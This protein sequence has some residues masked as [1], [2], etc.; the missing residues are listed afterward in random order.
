MARRSC[1]VRVKLALSAS[2]ACPL[3]KGKPVCTQTLPVASAS[4]MARHSGRVASTW[5]ARRSNSR[6]PLSSLGTDSAST[7]STAIERRSSTSTAVTS[8]RVISSP[9]RS[10]WARCCPASSSRPRPDIRASGSRP[11]AASRNSRRRSGTSGRAQ[12]R[13]RRME[14]IFPCASG[15]NARHSAPAA[16]APRNADCPSLPMST[17]PLHRYWERRDFRATPEPKGRTA[18]QRGALHFV[19]QKHHARRLHYDFRLELDGTLKSWAV[20]KGPSLD[21][22]D[23][24]MAVHVEDHPLDYAGFEGTIPSGQYGA[25]EVIVWDRGEWEPEGDAREGLP[26][27]HLKFR[28][29]GDKLEGGWALVRMHGREREKQEPPG[30][31]KATTPPRGADAEGVLGAKD[32]WLLIKER[33]EHARTGD[34]Y[35]V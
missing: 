16:R 26:K 3:P 19:V 13:R 31:P 7:S 34:E 8:A 1:S 2:C 9:A 11:A 22:A 20:P 10:A 25:G 23:K 29:H 5:R 15:V 33:D 4:T 21:P 24:R 35:S 28:L 32:T 12:E 17:E 14:G 27:G 6:A 30:R 18:K